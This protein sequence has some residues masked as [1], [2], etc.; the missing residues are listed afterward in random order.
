MISIS[1]E[2]DCGEPLPI[3]HSVMLWNKISTVGSQVVYT[4][5]PG[6]HSLRGGNISVCT[7]GGEW[8]GASLLCQGEMIHLFIE[9]TE[10]SVF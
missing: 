6:Y 1:V 5:N 2:V 8:D 7:A 10:L 9:C 3:P 4:C